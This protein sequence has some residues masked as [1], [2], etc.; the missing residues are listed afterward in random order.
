MGLQQIERRR[1]FEGWLEVYKH[2]STACKSPMTFAIYLPPQVKSGKRLPALYWLSGLTCTHENFIIKAGAQRYAAEHGLILVVPDTSPRNTGIPGEKDNE[3]LGEGASFYVNATQA[4]WNK[5]YQMFDYVT[6]ELPKLIEDN[7][8]VDRE[9]R[10]I[11]GHSMGGHGA[12][13]S[14]LRKPEHYVSVSAFA[15]VCRPT[16]SPWGRNAL[17]TYLG[18]D[19][20]TWENYDATALLSKSTIKRP[21]LLDQGAADPALEER[22]RPYDL[23]KV[24]EEKNIP[25]T[26][27]MR[28]GYDHSYYYVSSFIGEHIAYHAK[29]LGL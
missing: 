28:E 6:E 18:D 26:V 10:S 2:D 19:E 15:P 8:P 23:I 3:H 16:Q 1:C 22:L 27:H 12:L 25:L 11:S 4:P 9:K 7:F 14:F 13:I 29:A 21:I 20:K 24:A 5:H 17:R